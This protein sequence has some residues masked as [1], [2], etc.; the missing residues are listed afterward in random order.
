MAGQAALPL[1]PLA[2]LAAPASRL[3]PY[4]DAAA[5]VFARHGITRSSVPDV[6]RDLGVSRV[7]VYRQVGNVESMARLLLA[8]ELH[9]LLA[10]LPADLEGATGP[11]TF[12][13]L[14]TVVVDYLRTHPVAV[15]V[16]A[17]EPQFVG[18]FVATDLPDLIE[19][20]TAS[21]APLLESAMDAGI[22]ARRDPEIVASWL[23]RLVVS[24][25][26]APP[27][28][29]V[30]AFVAELVVPALAPGE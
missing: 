3:D 29:D 7:T 19:R 28:G 8:R 5:R 12:V 26:L 16:L 20:V 18:E 30:A 13:R 6:A 21:A 10:Q 1:F 2:L 11:E 27:P 9:R 17:D 4:L 14:V 15:K 23:A 24:L 22:I 25:V